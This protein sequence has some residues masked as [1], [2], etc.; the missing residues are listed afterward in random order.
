MT[1]ILRFLKVLQLL[2]V[3]YAFLAVLFTTNLLLVSPLHAFLSKALSG[4]LSTENSVSW[5]AFPVYPAEEPTVFE[6]LASALRTTESGTWSLEPSRDLI[7][8]APSEHAIDYELGPVSTTTTTTV[9]EGLF[10]SK[11]FAQSMRPSK[12]VPFF[13]QA[14]GV[15]DPE[16]IT[17]TTHIT[18]NR[19]K[20]FAPLVESY[21]GC[22]I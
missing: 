1:V 10:L 3:C 11:A 14:T 9:T 12:I 17:V 16:D 18:S 15:F 20:I 19:F 21:Q 5:T 4:R 13:Y 22:L 8:W 7:R 6:P 2:V